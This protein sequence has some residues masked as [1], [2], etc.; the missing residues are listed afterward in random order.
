MPNDL[1]IKLLRVFVV[2]GEELHFSR[3]AQRLYL[4]QQAVSRDIR[5]LESR[6]GSQL[7]DR[8]TRQVRLTPAGA[9]ML[10]RAREILALHDA[11]VRQLRGEPQSLTVDVVGPGLTPTLVVA[12][13]REIAINTEFF[14]RY[15]TGSQAA[16]PLLATGGLDVTF[17][18]HPEPV[19][20]VVHRRVRHER[21]GVLLAEDSPL[22]AK[23]EVPLTALRGARP[24]VRAGE[25][26]TP[27]W[28]HA[29]MQLLTPFGVDPAGA[30]P[31]VHG[32]DE[33]RH[34]VRAR[35]A[36]VLTLITQPAVPGTVVRPL[37]EPAAVFP[38]SMYW[39]EGTD[40]PGLMALHQAIDEL[41]D[42]R[43]WLKLPADPWLPYPENSVI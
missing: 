2:V 17:G 34:H 25:H 30:H 31:H 9:T 7:L 35:N 14:V 16:V 29:I 18:R 20:G 8:T 3:A 6:L 41:V 26:A 39:R 42:R 32:A 4:T 33:L 13:A 22:A 24:C 27:G 21:I 10:L 23:S 43:H 12:A 11:T 40:H 15:Y 36:P 37:R 1:E 5:S 19:S 28:E 38:W